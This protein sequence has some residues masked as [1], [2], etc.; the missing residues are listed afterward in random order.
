MLVVLY[1]VGRIKLQDSLKLAATTSADV[2]EFSISVQNT[3]TIVILSLTTV[4]ICQL[5]TAITIQ[6]FDDLIVST[7]KH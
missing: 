5:Y 7:N 2:K 4:G 6:S 1:V 3:S